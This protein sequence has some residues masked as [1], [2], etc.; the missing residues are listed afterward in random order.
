[1]FALVDDENVQQNI[2][3]RAVLNFLIHN[4]RAVMALYDG[5]YGDAERVKNL[6]NAAAWFDRTG[7]YA[8]EAELLIELGAGKKNALLENAS[9]KYEKD[10]NPI[11]ANE[12]HTDAL[13]VAQEEEWGD[14]ELDETLNSRDVKGSGERAQIEENT[15]IQRIIWNRVGNAASNATEEA[16]LGAIRRGAAPE[17]TG[18]TSKQGIKLDEKAVMDLKDGL[19]SLQRRAAL[20]FNEFNE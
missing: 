18:N 19:E 6:S 9:K 11:K 12:M 16:V 10:G 20:K 13:E 7:D 4:D 5:V 3:D 14:S 2:K 1:M 15:I 17:V 8:A